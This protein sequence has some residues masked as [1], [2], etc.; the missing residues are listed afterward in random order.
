MHN[1]IWYKRGGKRD[2]QPLIFAKL[3]TEKF[4]GAAI[5]RRFR[6]GDALKESSENFREITARSVITNF[7]YISASFTGGLHDS[8]C[9]RFKNSDRVC[10]PAIKEL[11]RPVVDEFSPPVRS[12]MNGWPALWGKS[13][14]KNL[15][16]YDEIGASRGEFLF[17]LAIQCL[18]RRS[19]A[20]DQPLPLFRFSVSYLISLVSDA[21]R[22]EDLV[23]RNFLS[24]LK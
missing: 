7:S 15:S 3:Q 11:L 10:V 6:V 20:W 24:R 23:S 13:I 21:S 8:A 22:Y 19:F 12:M 1:M 18:S 9:S 17:L 5:H 4:R 16:R 2:C 14:I